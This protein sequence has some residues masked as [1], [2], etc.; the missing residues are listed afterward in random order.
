MKEPAKLA[1]RWLFALFCLLVPLGCWP[2]TAAQSLP[3]FATN[4][5][6]IRIN[7]ELVVLHATVLNHERMRVPRLGKEAFQIYEDGTLQEIETI[8]HE[9]IPVTVGLVIDSSGSMQPKRAE[10]IAAALA[11]V[12]LSNP[13]DQHFLVKFN[14][15]VS[16]GLPA[17]MPFTASVSQLEAALVKI[18]THGKTALYDAVAAALAHAKSGKRDKQVLIVVSDG[19]DNASQKDKEQVIALAKQAEAIIYTIGIFDLADPDRNPGT[20]KQLAK[21]TGGEAFFPSS[22][23]EVT[24]ICESIARDIRSQY[25]LTYTPVKVKYDGKFRA[26]Q[27]KAKAPGGERLYVRT[28]AGYYSAATP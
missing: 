28:R 5:D 14:E 9:D 7:V 15:R 17:D 18:T 22:V 4:Q 11:F 1:R 8:R 20:L 6:A 16:F 13:Q 24:A 10:V 23:T 3:T 19:A 21:A 26:I 27:V 12:R 2:G 25:T